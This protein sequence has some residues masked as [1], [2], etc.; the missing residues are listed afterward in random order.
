[1]KKGAVPIPYIIG[2]ILGIIIVGLLGYWF[3][4]LGGRLPGVIT[5]QECNKRKTEYCTKWSVWGYAE[6]RKPGGGWNDYA[7]GCKEIGIDVPDKTECIRLFVGLKP[8][9]EL[10]EANGEC[11]SG[12]C[13][14]ET[15]KCDTPP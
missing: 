9:G 12:F 2:L 15:K 11:A 3:F 5:E 8:I 7:P 10:C 6:D 13:N 1:M 4:V 14:P